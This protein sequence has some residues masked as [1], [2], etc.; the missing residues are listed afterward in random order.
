MALRFE[1]V[2]MPSWPPLAWLTYCERGNSNLRVHH[3]TQVELTE[4]FFCEAVWAGDYTSGAIDETDIVAG[5]GGR[6]RGES[7]IFVSPG[8]TVDRLQFMRNERGV[9]VS[10]SLPCLLFASGA[11]VDPTYNRYYE[12]FYSIVNGL[13]GYQRLLITSEGAVELVYFNNLRWDGDRLTRVAKPGGNERLD[14]FGDYFSFLQKNMAEIA[15]NLASPQRRLPY[16]MLGT[17]STGYDSTTVTALSSAAGCEEVI[18]FDSSYQGEDDSGE[19]IAPYLGVKPIRVSLSGWRQLKFP[20]VPFIAANS[21]GE[22]VRFAAAEKLLAGRVL[23]TG[24]HG[25]KMWDL[26]TQALGRTI[27]RGDP[28]GL[29]LTEYRLWAGFIH[30]PVPFWGVRQISAINQVSRAEE[31]KPWDVGGDYT[32]PICRRIAESR[33]VPR[34]LFGVAK[35]NS[36]VILHNFSDVLTPQSLADLAQ[37][38]R[39]RRRAWLKQG[40]IPPMASVVLDRAWHRGTT[41]FANWA[42]KKPVIWR[43]ASWFESKPT[44]LRRC[45]FPWAIERAKAR[46]ANADGF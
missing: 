18:C 3:G 11:N 45:L 22:E 26:H 4:S 31:Q 8:T 34:E 7:A 35:R 5:S 12:D 24:Y 42:V 9:W 21:M 33:G 2:A 37:W 13:D 29:A 38:I 1:Y 15:A 28:S 14:S 10:N 23:M 17:L 16:R 30:C 32:R 43:A 46:Y 6:L 40:R 39:L 20:E 25:D 19:I 44:A 27:V 41:E 36:S